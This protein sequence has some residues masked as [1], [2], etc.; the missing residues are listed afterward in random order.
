MKE[1]S[2]ND[3]TV[4]LIIKKYLHRQIIFITLYELIFN[5]TIVNLVEI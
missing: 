3:K 1:I 5:K 2:F 4:L